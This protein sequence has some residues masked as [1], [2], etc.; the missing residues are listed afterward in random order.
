[1]L[2][3]L[4]ATAHAADVVETARAALGGMAD[5]QVGVLPLAGGGS[6]VRF[7]PVIDGT[8][9]DRSQRVWIDAAG[10]VR[11]YAQPLPPHVSDAPISAERALAAAF[12]RFGP[13]PDARMRL[14]WRPRGGMLQ[15]IWTVDA[16]QPIAGYEQPLLRIDAASGAL[17]GIDEGA[18]DAV[19]NAYFENPTL[20]AYPT[21]VSLPGAETALTDARVTLEQ[22]RDLGDVRPYYFGSDDDFY[23]LDVHVCTRVPAN[24]P[25]DGDYLYDPTFPTDPAR[26]EDDFAPPHTYFN[27]HRGLDF[28]DALGWTVPNDFDPFL[29]V[30]VNYRTADLWSKA[31]ATDPSAAL[32][33]YDNA[34][35]SGGYF[36]WKGV[37]VPPRLVFGQGTE[38][39]F[40]YDADVIHHELTHFVVNT[41]D[42]PSRSEHGSEGPSVQANALNEGLADYFSCALQGDPNLAEYAGGEETI[43]NLAGSETCMDDLYGESHYDSLPFSQAL[44][45]YRDSLSE[46]DRPVFD[47]AVL[48]G[49]SIMGPNASFASASEV[50]V[51]LAD[52]RLGD[53][54]ALADELDARGVR[55]CRARVPVEPGK[56]FRLFTRVPGSYELANDG[57]VPGYVQFVVDIPDG[58]ATV[59]VTFGQTRYLGLD[60]YGTNEPQAI[61][62]VGKPGDGIAWKSELVKEKVTFDGKEYWFYVEVWSSDASAVAESVETGAEPSK[63]DPQYE[64]RW[65]TVSWD[66]P[67]PGP[68]TFQFTNDYD[69]LAT[70]G[71]LSLTLAD[72]P[73]PKDTAD[74][75]SPSDAPSPDGDEETGG[76]ACGALR[77]SAAFGWI[78]A[79]AFALSRRASA[80]ASRTRSRSSTPCR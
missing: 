57:P 19:A 69:R 62:V 33:P 29:Y 5:A 22:C 68:Y 41:Q 42:G 35:S 60:Q 30:D 14:S 53:G 39:D 61:G 51:A 70:L 23:T 71:H 28:F 11:P 12:Q 9:V 25:V 10:R 50:L 44:W 38:A 17:I 16:R 36:D 75:G 79:L 48:D 43:R 65:S 80:S 37:W 55:N 27:V 73:L 47:Q 76:C 72:L 52:E 59:T 56:E 3:F 74:T 21:V 77:G 26:D 8:P 34:Y 18:V 63:T 58:G 6:V 4:L 66:V 15:R 13:L 45:A 32:Q 67:S 7:V 64:V 49:M 20:E 2:L 46:K 54:K 24:G 40:A 1:M 78:A 31:T